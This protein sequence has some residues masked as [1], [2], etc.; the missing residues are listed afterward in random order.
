MPVGPHILWPLAAKKSTSSARTSIGKVRH[1]LRSVDEHDG[2]R[3]VGARHDRFERRDR[4]QRVGN[5]R[6]RDEL[7]A[8]QQ[9]V[10]IVENVH[11]SASTRNEAQFRT[12]L[13]CQKLPRHEIGMVFELR[14]DDRVTGAEVRQR[15]T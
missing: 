2:A 6:E 10:E 13:G 4:A 15:P 8:P 3:S 9:P 14:A 5:V 11:P 12:G 1:R 7:S